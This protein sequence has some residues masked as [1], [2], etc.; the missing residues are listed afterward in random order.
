MRH[1]LP[2]RSCAFALPVLALVLASTAQSVSTNPAPGTAKSGRTHAPA[3]QPRP[4]VGADSPDADPALTRWE[5][6]AQ[7]V[8]L[9]GLVAAAR[10]GG[11]HGVGAGIGAQLAGLGML[12]GEFVFTGSA[13]EGDTPAGIAFSA[14]GARLIVAHRDSRNL[15]VFDAATRVVMATVDLSGSPNALAVSSD[16]IHV[17]T[18][19]VFE[20]TASIVDLTTG[21]ETAVVS[22]G[23]QPGV[24]RIT[25]DGTTAVVGNTVDADL[26]V[27]DIATATEVRR[28][29]N[30]GFVA[31]VTMAFEPGVITATFS[32][33]EVANDATIVHPDYYAGHVQVFDIASGTAT[34]LVTDSNPRGIDVTPGGAI[35]VVSH[36]S[37]VQKISV[38]D[39]PGKVV[40]K[41]IPIGMDC[42]GPICVR[43]DGTKAAV[44]VQNACRIVDLGTNAVTGNLST[45]SV[46]ELHATADGNYAQCIGFYGSLLDFTTGTR[47]KDLNGVVSCPLGA[48][49]PVGPRAAMVANSFGE[50]LVV[51]NTSGAA[52]YTEGIVPSGVPPE[53]DCTRTV[54]VSPDGSQIVA[55][56]I[57]GDTAAILDA[58]TGTVQAIVDVGDRPAEVA[59]TPDGSLAVVA[60]LDSYHA[61]IINLDT[62][63]VTDVTIGRRAS[64]VEIS[65][66]GKY[67]Y[68]C[69]VANGDGV[70]RIDLDTL[71]VAG[72]KIATADMSS[73]WFLFYQT[74]GMTL[75]HDGGTLVVCGTYSDQISI[76]DTATWSLAKTM[77]V[78]DSPVRATFSP[79]DSTIYVTS[80]DDD[81]VYEVVNAGAASAITREIPVGDYPFETVLSPDGRTLYVINFNAQNIGLV[82]LVTGVMTST[83][84]LQ[85]Y[86]AGLH[87]D[88]RGRYLFVPTGTYSVTI[89]P[90]PVFT[91][92]SEGQVVMIDTRLGAVV[93]TLDTGLP[94]AMLAFDPHDRWGVI[95]SP[96]GDG[97][98]VIHPGLQ[99]GQER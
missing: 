71:T 21:L 61:S 88:G 94:P 33:F 53:L 34:T 10:R 77:A 86:A 43:P 52:G 31:S 75:S 83:I 12:E 20:D 89:G 95:P 87:L 76:I 11:S 3:A 56:G 70:W 18:A 81:K 92:S 80:R 73:I 96:L 24:V 8:R 78:G 65:P 67:A 26:S 14:D 2:R 64:Q 54:A 46:Y 82:D 60:N 72:P 28:I 85:S 66:D 74:S 90:G 97:V 55:V 69:V 51:V 57:L 47:I 68:L 37:S 79:D 44:A 36:T 49:S 63:A 39:V 7:E 15:I 40:T 5:R 4:L 38:I 93:H 23:Q 16:G 25:P 62:Y 6:P 58:A 59:I 84:G 29:P 35:A 48:V 9:A 42:W 41:T 32:E 27:I 99:Y 17:V 30:A 98:T 50:D 91:I 45:A 19:N 13:P 1:C 22:V